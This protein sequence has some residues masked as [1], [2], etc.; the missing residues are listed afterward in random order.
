MR[1]Q[2][3]LI[4]LWILIIIGFIAHTQTDMLPAFWGQSIAL[5]PSDKTPVGMIAFMAAL[6][7]TLPVTA[8]LI[9]IYGKNKGMKRTNAFLA[10]IYAL[11]CILH[12]GEWFDSFNPVQLTI[13]P[14]MA[15]IGCILAFKSVRY[16]KQ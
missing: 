4:T 13:M 8:I 12:M 10:C 2:I 9:V 14:L 5:M 6:T 3:E 15:I 1:K 11:F 7:Y 16:S